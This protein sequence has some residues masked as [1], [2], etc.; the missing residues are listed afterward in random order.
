MCAIAQTRPTT[1]SRMLILAPFWR[2]FNPLLKRACVHTHTHTHTHT[3]IYICHS[4]DAANGLR[5]AVFG[6][7]S[8][9]A[10]VCLF[11]W[12]QGEW[13][14][15][16]APHKGDVG[17]K[18]IATN[19]IYITQLLYYASLWSLIGCIYFYLQGLRYS[20]YPIFLFKFTTV[21][22]FVRSFHQYPL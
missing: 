17:D 18:S 13:R 19:A 16:L 9:P 14:P 8:L 5:A 4:V 10:S 22:V 12:Q 21:H 15:S 1:R 20:E 11:L 7:V 3:Y 6:V 2:L